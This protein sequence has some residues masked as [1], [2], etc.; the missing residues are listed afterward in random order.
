[1][2][3]TI[4]TND[5]PSVF[6][7]AKDQLTELAHKYWL[8]QDGSKG[9]KFNKQVVEDIFNKVSSNGF[10]LWDLLVLDHSQYLERCGIFSYF[11]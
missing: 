9:R 7:I 2:V 10:S 5:R 1:M 3:S 4:S 11:L 6:E 8:P